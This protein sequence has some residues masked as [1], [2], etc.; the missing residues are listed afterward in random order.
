MNHSIFDTNGKSKASIKKSDFFRVM[1]IVCLTEV[2]KCNSHFPKR[3]KSVGK[4]QSIRTDSFSDES[5]CLGKLLK[6]K[7]PPDKEAACPKINFVHHISFCF[8]CQ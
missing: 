8:N 4:N 2:A 3:R 6:W 7:K 5:R 1:L